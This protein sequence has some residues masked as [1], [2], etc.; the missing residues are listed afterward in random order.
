MGNALIDLAN[1]AHLKVIGVVSSEEKARFVRDL[2]ADHVINRKE[3]KVSER[4]NE[5]TAGRGVEAIIDPVAEPSFPENIEMLAPCGTLLIYGALAERL[6]SISCQRRACAGTRQRFGNSLST[7]GII[8]LKSAALACALSSIC[9]Q[10]ESSVRA[11]TLAHLLARQRE[12]TR[13]WRAVP[14]WASCCCCRRP[15]WRC[16]LL[17]RSRVLDPSAFGGKAE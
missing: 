17:A 5:I 1:V 6:N 9:L 13:C 3:I 4:V 14:S 10:P 15:F 7:P 12:H 8:S 2:G 11:Y 16:R